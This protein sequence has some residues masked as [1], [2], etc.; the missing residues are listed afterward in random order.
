[1]TA[2]VVLLGEVAVR[3]D[4]R[5]VD[6]GP[7]KQR[8]VL[9][10]LAVDA[11]RLVPA[12]RLV[13]RV[14]G[15]DAPRRGRKT[16][17]SYLSRLRRALSGTDGVAV[18]GRSGGYA[19]VVDRLDQVID[20]HR[21]RELCV[22]AREHGDDVEAARLLTEALA[23]WRGSALTGVNGAWVD[24]ERDRL[25][26]ERLAA[27]N[28][29]SDAR[30]RLGHGARL[31][32][33][34]AA[35][36]AEHPWD[37]RVAGQYMLALH[38][39]GR[40]ADALAHYRRLRER[41]VA[42]LGT[43]PGAALRE[44]HRQVLAADPAL[45]PATTDPGGPR[46][47]PLQLPSAPALFTGRVPELAE[48]D[49]ALATSD[50]PAGH[51][52]GGA[53]TTA[54]ISAIGGTGGVGKTWLALT[55]ANRNLH[56]F[57]DGQLFVDLRGFSPGDPKQATEVLADFLSALGVERD[58]QPADPD[59]RAAL[60]RTHTTGKRLLV[61][62]DN[63]AS[64]EQVV[65]LLPGGG[66]CT[67]L[68]TSRHRLPALLARHGARPV[69][70]G[71]LTD[72]E[73]RALLDTALGAARGADVERAV[74]ELI[75]WCGGFPLALGL[76][77]ARVRSHPDLLH[78]VVAELREHGLHALDSDDPEA[79]LPAVLSWSL[80]H[81]TERQREVFA[82]LGVAPGPD[83]DPHAAASLTGS[84][85]PD[86]RAVLRALTDAS[87]I[88]PVPGG[89][90]A[91]HDLVRAYAGA[92]AHAT[93]P[94]AVRRAALDRVV[95]FYLHT[96]HTADRLL[97][98]H[99]ETIRLAP[100]A[101]GVRP[102]QLPDVPAALAWL[103]THHP[104]LLAAQ[105]TAIAHRRHETVWHLA[106][107]LT[108]FQRHRGHRHD[109]LAVWRAAADAELPDLAARTLVHRLLGDAHAALGQHEVAVAHLHEA[110][111]LAERHGNHAQQA[112][113]HHT[114][115]WVWEQRGDD[116]Q[117]LE[118]ARRALTLYRALDQPVGEAVALNAV[119]WYAARLGDHDSGR[120]DC[121]AGLALYRRHH[122][123]AGEAAALDSLGY[124][125]HHTGHHRQA[126]HHYR[127]AL[128]LRRALGNTNQAADTLDNLGHPHAALG[129]RAR[130][131]E[132]W[133]EALV[134]YREQG[135]NADAERV[136][137]QLRDLDGLDDTTT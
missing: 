26:Q 102:R 76:I 116:R 25:E 10:A 36:A 54:V 109:E 16:L 122:D 65:P 98:P 73:A 67:V 3:I 53:G 62:L 7:A 112:H 101:P 114:L 5:S 19:L 129:E 38:Q 137:R 118:H 43:D 83:T 55:W 81:L 44:L 58:R 92:T 6:L 125:E 21:F 90:Y 104:H 1:M 11:P 28:D 39:N 33:E 108:T 105:H 61:L 117:A 47:V 48:L 2:R 135:R 133:R 128:A 13:A 42:E 60:Y 24:A 32:V 99:R 50:D 57:P 124:I 46:A 91:M 121:R 74:A 106:W 82:L 93:L 23:L 94:A 35:R 30:L 123:L 100:P 31:V 132:V 70:V 72:A 85:T 77:A 131:R 75:A 29:L 37:E 14:W 40:T 17:Y 84:S 15:A 27:R 103:D 120:A 20:L 45:S 22:R 4:G 95:D 68:I 130:A 9:A 56:R 51:G 113:T 64:V 49:R 87:L 136:R 89:R 69:R 86:T 88:T 110:L 111:A 107:V 96:A 34:L 78:D 18:V 79:S 80:R 8:C 134:S 52:D 97:D 127:E 126:V 71:L 119:G 115:S 59:A 63:A 12:D 41:L 66:S